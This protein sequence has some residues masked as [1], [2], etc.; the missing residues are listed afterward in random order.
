M[1][2]D[3]PIAWNCPS[4]FPSNAKYLL[5]TIS[6]ILPT[7]S[8]PKYRLYRM[9]MLNQKIAWDPKQCK[10]SPSVRLVPLIV[11]VMVDPLALYR[12]PEC[13]AG[14]DC[15]VLF[16]AGCQAADFND[17]AMGRALIKLF[18]SC[19]TP[20]IPTS[21]TSIP[22][23]RATISRSSSAPSYV[24]HSSTLPSVQP[25][26]WSQHDGA[27]ARRLW[28]MPRVSRNHLSSLSSSEAYL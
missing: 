25:L 7:C 24:P 17:C 9:C 18:E 13:Y 8:I 16:G 2:H 6:L 27:L 4:L 22:A 23:L 20:T 5:A 15:E 11:A 14:M 19:R 3:T 21:A 28:V 12:L 26:P 1:E 10:L